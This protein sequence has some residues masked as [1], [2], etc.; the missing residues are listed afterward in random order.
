MAENRSVLVGYELY[1]ASF[2]LSFGNRKNGKSLKV[3]LG[4]NHKVAVM[5]FSLEQ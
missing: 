2:A 5:V 3:L 1:L 4:R